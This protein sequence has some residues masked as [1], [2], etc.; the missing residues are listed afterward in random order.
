MITESFPLGAE[1]SF[2]SDSGL[3]ARFWR[4]YETISDRFYLGRP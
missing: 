1:T 2:L 3:R 4:I